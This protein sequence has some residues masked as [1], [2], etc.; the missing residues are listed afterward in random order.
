MTDLK[1][2]KKKRRSVEA[3]LKLKQDHL[4]MTREQLQHCLIEEKKVTTDIE[5]LK[6]IQDQVNQRS[7]Q[8][9][10]KSLV[11]EQAHATSIYWTR[12]NKQIDELAKKRGHIANEIAELEKRIVNES[13]YVSMLEKQLAKQRITEKKLA[14]K[15][16]DTS[17][18]EIFKF[19]GLY[20]SN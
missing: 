18:I 1:M 20:G 17:A 2:L 6:I 4:S 10:G 5:D 15:K 19:G 13:R 12:Q 3:L 8:L 11:I 14:I 16:Q 9:L 7:K